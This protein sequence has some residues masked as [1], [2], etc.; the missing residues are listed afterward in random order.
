LNPSSPMPGSIAN[1][2]VSGVLPSLTT[3]ASQRL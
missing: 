2:T 1:S 3:F